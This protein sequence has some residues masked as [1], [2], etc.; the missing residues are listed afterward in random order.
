MT[1]AQR[2][3]ALRLADHWEWLHR[4]SSKPDDYPLSIG[5]E[6]AD[7]LRE[8]ASEPQAEPVLW[9]RDFGAGPVLCRPDHPQAKPLYAHP[10]Q[11][12]RPLTPE[13]LKECERKAMVN[14]ALPFEQREFF[15]R[16]IEAAHGITPDQ[17]Q[18][19]PC[20]TPR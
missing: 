12:R 2:A 11:Q 19:A 15:A 14:G 17:D 1:P 5:M 10:P 8:L 16:A 3:A 13:Q 4:N 20:P 9:Y 6:C 18:Q 7:L